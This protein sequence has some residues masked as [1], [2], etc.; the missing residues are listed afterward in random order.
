MQMCD[1]LL[2]EKDILHEEQRN[3]K[4]RFIKYI[5]LNRQQRTIY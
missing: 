5:R 4:K 2:V 1:N 3:K